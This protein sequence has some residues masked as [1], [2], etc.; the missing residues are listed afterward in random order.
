[1]MRDM[2]IS[3]SAVLN[4]DA[5]AARG[6]A[7]RKGLGKVRHIEVAQLWVRDRVASESLVINNIG[8][9]DNLTDVLTKYVD[10]RLMDKHTVR[11]RLHSE[12]GRHVLAP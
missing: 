1:M 4:T 6:I 10:K 5:S 8:T 3:L 7:L 11:M 9:G 12:S 2:G